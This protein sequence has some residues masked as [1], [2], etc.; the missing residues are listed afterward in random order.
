MKKL[1]ILGCL[2]LLLVGGAL[3]AGCGSSGGGSSVV[4]V[5]K[6]EAGG[7]TVATITLKAGNKGTMSLIEG[8]SGIGITYKVEDDTVVLIG[9]DG[10]TTVGSF[11]IEDDG[12][13]DSTTRVLFKK[14]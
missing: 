4:G 3:V 8:N 11:K 1:T 10:K 13:R 12:L 14:Q 6:A 5:Y 9:A 2:V 7:K